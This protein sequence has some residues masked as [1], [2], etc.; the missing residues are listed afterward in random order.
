LAGDGIQV[1]L[2]L[3][4]RSLGCDFKPVAVVILGIA[5]PFQLQDPIAKPS[6]TELIDAPE[7]TLFCILRIPSQTIAEEIRKP[8]IGERVV[9][10]G[11]RWFDL[12]T[13]RNEGVTELRRSATGDRFTTSPIETESSPASPL[14]FKTSQATTAHRITFV[15]FVPFGG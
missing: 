6:R 8:R 2:L 9:A 10:S 12:R 15:R 1:A 11:E 5:E 4:H 3:L 14:A 7:R 13:E